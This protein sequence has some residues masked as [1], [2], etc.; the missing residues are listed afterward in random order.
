MLKFTPKESEAPEAPRLRPL[1]EVVIN[2]FII[3]T[4]SAHFNQ[5]I[6]S[7]NV[8]NFNKL[9]LAHQEIATHL[10]KRSSEEQAYDVCDLNSFV[11]MSSSLTTLIRVQ[12]S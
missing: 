5:I 8:Q 10:F 3:Y 7:A 6:A 1:D 4:V 11:F 12:E 2:D 9:A